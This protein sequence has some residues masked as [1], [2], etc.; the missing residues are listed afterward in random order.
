[1]IAITLPDQKTVTRML[2]LE[3]IFDSFRLFQADIRSYCHF[4]IDGSTCKE[5]FRESDT[6]PSDDIAEYTGWDKIRPIAFQMI[7]GKRLPVSF[8]FSFSA[9]EQMLNE[10]LSC[11]PDGHP[12]KNPDTIEGLTFNIYYRNG[13]IHCTSATS[14]KNFSLDQSLDHLW[15]RYLIAFLDR[16]EIEYKDEL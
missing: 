9:S 1:M 11:L 7:K 2:F 15:D 5:Y 13:A 8:Q 4:Q 6:M 14:K 10:L 12:N 16:N 3:N